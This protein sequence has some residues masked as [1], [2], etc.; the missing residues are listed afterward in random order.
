VSLIY[1]FGDF[2]EEIKK[3]GIDSHEVCSEKIDELTSIFSEQLLN[4]FKVGIDKDKNKKERINSVESVAD[5]WKKSLATLS[6]FIELSLEIISSYRVKNASTAENEE[7]HQFLAL[8][9]L[10]AR[11]ILVSKE[12]LVLLENGFPDGAFARWRTLHEIA[13]CTLVIAYSEDTGKR[14]LLDEHIKNSKGSKCYNKYHTKLNHAPISDEI[15]KINAEREKEALSELGENYKKIGGDYE[16]A[17]PFIDSK[18]YKK[19][20]RITLFDLEKETNLDHY[21]P[22]YVWACGKTHAESKGN[23]A[24][25]GTK[26]ERAF[27]VGPS[28][29]GLLEPIDCT[30]LTLSVITYG[31]MTAYPCIDSIVLTKVLKDLRVIV[32]DTALS[33][34]A[35]F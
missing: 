8:I 6:N 30:A 33:D 24:N 29:H 18:N 22:Y 4:D 35:K 20:R 27:L 17:R 5:K 16:W 25:L 32:S 2:N 12:I 13:V 11:A 31:C 14:F 9:Q 26:N 23:Y 10:H 1:T 34:N 21:R 3:N 15:M 19:N 28:N 7:N